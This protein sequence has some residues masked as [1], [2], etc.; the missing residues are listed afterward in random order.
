[1][2][3]YVAKNN[4][5]TGPF[6]IEQINANIQAGLFKTD[7]LCWHDGIPNWMPISSLYS[8]TQSEPILQ[9][10]LD[11]E[12]SKFQKDK[13]QALQVW[14]FWRA[15]SLVFRHRGFL[16]NLLPVVSHDALQDHDRLGSFER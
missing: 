16:V 8:P 6:T 10:T 2:Q 4:E 11:S 14:P 12:Q 9:P 13:V 1:M 7:D 15:G 3:I 5:K